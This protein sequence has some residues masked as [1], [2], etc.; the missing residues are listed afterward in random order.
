MASFPQTTCH[1]YI[2]FLYFILLLKSLEEQL[3]LAFCLVAIVRNPELRQTE[4]GMK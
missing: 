1:H 2:L 3:E 4:S